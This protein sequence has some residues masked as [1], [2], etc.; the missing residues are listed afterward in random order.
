MA[1]NSGSSSE[2]KASSSETKASSSETVNPFNDE[3]EAILSLPLPRPFSV[4]E[5][6]EE[7]LK[8]V[9]GFI[10]RN[11]DGS[12]VKKFL[13]YRDFGKFLV[14]IYDN[15]IDFRLPDQL[16]YIGIDLPDGGKLCFT[17]VQV[18]MPQLKRGKGLGTCNF[19]NADMKGEDKMYPWIAKRDNKTYALAVYARPTYVRGNI[20]SYLSKGHCHIGDIPLPL[21]SKYCYLS[22][23]TPKEML[24]EGEDPDTAIG[25]F[26]IEGKKKVIMNYEK[27]RLNKP[28]LYRYKTDEFICRTTF[29]NYNGTSIVEVSYSKDKKIDIFLSSLNLLDSRRLKN[30]RK[31]DKKDKKLN[32]FHIFRYLTRKFEEDGSP[33]YPDYD[34]IISTYIFP[35]VKKSNRAKVVA[36]LAFTVNNLS[37]DKEIYDPLEFFM[38]KIEVRDDTPYKVEVT[39]NEINRVLDRDL[40]PN[41]NDIQ[42]EEVRNRMKLLNLGAMVARITE[43]MAGLRPLDNRDLWAN[44]RLESAGRVMEQYFRILWGHLLKKSLEVVL[45]K[46][47]A[48]QSTIKVDQCQPLWL[49]NNL[50]KYTQNSEIRVEKFYMGLAEEI[51]TNIKYDLVSESFRNAFAKKWQIKGVHSK[52]N[53]VQELKTDNKIATLSHILRLD[54]EGSHRGTSH[55]IRYV[56]PDQYGFICAVHTPDGEACG[57]V[58]NM[59]ITCEIS[60]GITFEMEVAFIERL[61]NMIRQSAGWTF[62]GKKGIVSHIYKPSLK[63]KFYY[64][65]RFLGWCEPTKTYNTIYQMKLGG[66][67]IN[68]ECSVSLDKDDNIFVFTDNSRVIRP[69]LLVDEEGK[70]LVYRRLQ[71]ENPDYQFTFTDLLERGAATY[72]DPHEQTYIKLASFEDSIKEFFDEEKR[73][74]DIYNNAKA[75][76]EKA[77][78]SSETEKNRTILELDLEKAE[79]RHERIMKRRRYTHCELHPQALLSVSASIIPAPQTNQSARNT[80][81]AGTA[82]QALSIFHPNQR[83][84]FDGKT[85]LLAFP[86]NPIFTTEMESVFRVDKTPQGNNVIVAF[87]SHPMT[88]E[89]AFVMSQRAVDLGLF[90]VIKYTPFSTVL[91]KQGNYIDEIRRP[92][93]AEF[94]SDRQREPFHAIGSNGLPDINAHLKP[95]DVVISSFRTDIQTGITVKTHTILGT[96]E[97]GVVHDVSITKRPDESRIVRVTL[98]TVRKPKVGDKYAARNAQKGTVSLVLKTEDMPWTENGMI[99]DIIVNPHA[100]PSRMTLSYLIEILTGKVGAMTGERVN[101]TPFDKIDLDQFFTILSCMGYNRDGTERMYSGATGELLKVPIFIGPAYFQALR[102]QVDEKAQARSRGGAI[103]MTTRQPV[104]GRSISALKWYSNI[105]LV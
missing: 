97:E 10:K 105:L 72:V 60:R 8:D 86:S 13:T 101:A 30:G 85:K 82:T 19:A 25:Y 79:M 29:E 2:T 89:D 84:Q 20:K 99:P 77:L 43:Y 49:L 40:F 4:E 35:F 27:I 100:I 15:W 54:I 21:R 96:G 36:E 75:A 61:T 44:K 3:T 66:D 73:S 69:L 59:A 51:T 7:M 9:P 32:V 78:K 87:M 33:V 55:D 37:S 88:G 22:K 70:E 31:L 28:L 68:H 81:Q 14:D 83:N 71:R 42:G 93:D 45:K 34:T 57:M 103:K 18:E 104:E 46:K 39:T 23:M 52:D 80:F 92:T 48:N 74:E 50:T 38:D 17:D 16:R 62:R 64:N 1:K 26:I 67:I 53:V 41:L 76:Y 58:K 94:E 90:S 98:R 95:G 6:D 63:G 56:Q 12:W 102:H 5:Y 47:Y 24:K 11:S 91:T 65:G